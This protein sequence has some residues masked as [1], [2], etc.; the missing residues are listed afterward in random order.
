MDVSPQPQTQIRDIRSKR[1]RLKR[2]DEAIPEVE[3]KLVLMIHE[4]AGLEAIITK[5]ESYELAKNHDGLCG[6]KHHETDGQ[7]GFGADPEEPCKRFYGHTGLHSWQG[8]G[9]G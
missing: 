8:G 1:L 2:L 7:I 4:R 6:L 5:V 9:E 3:R